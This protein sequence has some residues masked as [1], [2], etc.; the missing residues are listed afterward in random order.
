MPNL[1]TLSDYFNKLTIVDSFVPTFTSSFD[2]LSKF[3]RLGLIQFLTLSRFRI[4]SVPFIGPEY[5]LS[6]SDTI[7][8]FEPLRDL[9]SPEKPEKLDLEGSWEPFLNAG[10]EISRPENEALS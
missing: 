8:S 5:R 7:L 1:N 2:R 10:M 3:L 4:R 9:N 6:F